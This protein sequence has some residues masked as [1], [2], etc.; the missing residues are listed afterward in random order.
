MI[1]SDVLGIM[2]SL[3]SRSSPKFRSILRSSQRAS[4]Y[5]LSSRH[6][7][8]RPGASSYRSQSSPTIPRVAITGRLTGPITCNGG[9]IVINPETLSK[10]TAVIGAFNAATNTGVVA[11]N[12][13]GP[14]GSSVGPDDNVILGC[15]PQNNPSDVI[16]L[17]INAKTKA[18]TPITHITG[19]DEVW[20]NSGDG[21]YYTGC[22]SGLHGPGISLSGGEP[23]DTRARRDRRGSQHVDRKGPAIVGLAFGGGGFRAQSY[24]RPPGGPGCDRW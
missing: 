3:T 20:Y 12:N 5:R 11:L 22:E 2:R 17:V 15:T 23:A 19:S 14:N 7:I 4:G 9:V 24:L 18:Q 8:R 10:P 6:G 16:S 21:R 13:C 1:T